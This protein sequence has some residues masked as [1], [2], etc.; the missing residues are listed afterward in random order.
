MNIYLI[1]FRCT[2]K[3]S[4]G[5][6]LAAALNWSFVDADAE[7]ERDQGMSI[8]DIVQQQGWEAFRKMEQT[9][10]AKLCR[11][12]EYVVATGGGV[13]LDDQ[14]VHRMKRSGILIWLRATP[15]TIER[16][17]AADPN[18]N[19]SRPALTAQGILN[20]IEETL[21]IRNPLYANAMD[22]WID[23]DEAAVDDI[24]Q[25]ILDIL[26]SDKW[27]VK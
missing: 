16:R 11:L 3:T 10:I 22:F 7:I 25:R 18:T 15:D 4:V 17:M 12:R 20:E 2:G 23:T 9:V 27:G 19:R 6:R 21:W 26:N 8:Q 14:N 1:G 13:V 5:Q 24:G